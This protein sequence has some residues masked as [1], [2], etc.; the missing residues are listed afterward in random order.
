MSTE[1]QFLDW[2]QRSADTDDFAAIEQKVEASM[3]RTAPQDRVNQIMSIQGAID[4]GR[5]LR[6]KSRIARIARA[7]QRVDSAMRRAGR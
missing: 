1:H 7:M 5:S 3:M 2:L 6:E 4:Q